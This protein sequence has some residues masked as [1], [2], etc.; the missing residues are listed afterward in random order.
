MNH[1]FISVISGNC[2]H[3]SSSAYPSHREGGVEP[4]PATTDRQS[5][6]ANTW[7]KTLTVTYTPMAYLEPP[8]PN[9]WT[10]GRTQSTQREPCKHLNSTQKGPGQMSG[11]SCCKVTIL[12]TMH[13]LPQVEVQKCPIRFVASLLNGFATRKNKYIYQYNRRS[14][15]FWDTQNDLV[16]YVCQML[17]NM[18]Y[19]SGNSQAVK[20]G[21]IAC[22]PVM[23]VP[24]ALA[25][26]LFW[27][28]LKLRWACSDN[29]T[30][31]KADVST[32]KCY[33]AVL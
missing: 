25:L 1:L 31:S 10:T 3:P 11:P 33:P 9:N 28:S 22:Y 8:K 18:S 32:T 16:I 15:I 23:F 14:R 2:I 13:M 27:W 19:F 5:V 17:W 4:I 26:I 12:I 30:Y 6:T 21:R 7:R 24:I 20:P 29:L